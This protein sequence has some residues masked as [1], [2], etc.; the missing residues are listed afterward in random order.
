MLSPTHTHHTNLHTNTCNTNSTHTN[1]TPHPHTSPHTAPHA[2]TLHPHNLTHPNTQAD[3]GHV[4]IALQCLSCHY[5]WR[6]GNDDGMMPILWGK[7]A[8]PW[9]ETD[10][11]P[12]SSLLS[13]YMICFPLESRTAYD[14]LG[15]LL[16]IS[17]SSMAGDCAVKREQTQ[18]QIL[19]IFR[20]L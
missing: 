4:P 9:R 11:L 6:P 17:S 14:M 5:P 18:V 1:H 8:C 13:P 10:G 7:V 12:S 2:Q 16:T 20:P 15:R 19:V 3:L